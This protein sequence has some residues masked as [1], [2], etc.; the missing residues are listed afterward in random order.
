MMWNDVKNLRAKEKMNNRT[1]WFG[2]DLKDP[3]IP[4][5]LS[6]AG[7]PFMRSHCLKPNYWPWTLP[8]MGYE[9]YGQNNVKKIAKVSSESP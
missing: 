7:T 4:N 3:L 9:R 1:P 5:P 6:G 2:R 8:G